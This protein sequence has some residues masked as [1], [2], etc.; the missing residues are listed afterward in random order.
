MPGRDWRAHWSGT[1]AAGSAETDD[2]LRQVGK[3]VLGVPVD[4]SQLDLIVH[5]IADRLELDSTDHVL[6]LGCGNGLITERIA[7]VA[8]T[9]CAL[10]VSPSL[11]GDARRYRNPPNV[12]YRVADLGD[13]VGLGACPHPR[14][15]AYAYEVFQHLVAEDVDSLLKG[16]T[17][18]SPEGL[19]LWVGSIPDRARIR[20]FYDTPERWDLYLRRTAEGTEQIGTWWDRE[21]LCETA[22]RS[23]FGCSL[24]DQPENLYTAHY[25]FD[26]LLVLPPR[27]RRAR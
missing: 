15:K 22:Q 5:G 20:A 18:H 8:G 24:F 25:R 17:A 26:A 6:D 11:I 21:E 14:H 1:P 16:L 3:T 13:G 7:R 12:T 9:V 27:S 19:R 4:D 23:G 10:D 2:A